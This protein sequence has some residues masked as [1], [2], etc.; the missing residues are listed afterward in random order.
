M[1]QRRQI[2]GTAL[3]VSAA[4]A[5]VACLG[6]LPAAALAENA[7]KRVLSADTDTSS[8]LYADPEN[9]DT[10]NLEIMPL[11]EFGTMG[12][13]DIALDQGDWR[14]AVT[15]KVERELEL[16]YSEIRDLPAIVREVLLICPGV[17]A[18]HGRWRGVS[19]KELIRLSRPSDDASRVAIH[20][21]SSS[22]T[23]TDSFDIEEASADKVFLAYRVNG[24]K[25]PQKH[26]FPLRVVA[27]DHL[28]YNWTKY[29]V[30]VEFL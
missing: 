21:R 6:G 9:L 22:G 2:L 25:L 30:R 24:Q 4:A 29:V 20:G 17:F 27:E 8:L 11:R 13:T 16:T 12:D 3:R 19:L 26:G 1:V 23:Q 5:A 10:S 18:N 28:G 7:S 15:G 14:L